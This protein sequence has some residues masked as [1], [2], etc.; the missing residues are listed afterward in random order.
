[1]QDNQNLVQYAVLQFFKKS[2]G[3]IKVV[4][5]FYEHKKENQ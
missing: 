2:V 5:Y 4:E 3:T 1:M